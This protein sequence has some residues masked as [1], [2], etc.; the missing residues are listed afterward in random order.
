[1]GE[2]FQTKFMPNDIIYVLSK[3]DVN[4]LNSILVADALKL[5]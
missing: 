3:K 4:F 2:N 1:M 5:I